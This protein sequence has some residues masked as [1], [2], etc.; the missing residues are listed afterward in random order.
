VIFIKILDLGIE[1]MFF[2]YF[3]GENAIFHKKHA[4]AW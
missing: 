3:H 4:T 2:V 1:G